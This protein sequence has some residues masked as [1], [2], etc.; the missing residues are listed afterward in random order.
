MKIIIAIILAMGC[1]SVAY[2]QV[3]GY[4]DKEDLGNGLVKVKS[5]N[6][7]GIMDK[8]DNVIVSVEYQDIV[9]R[10]G[11]ALLIK[12]GYLRGIVDSIGNIK[13][14]NGEYKVHPKYKYVSEG[15]IPVSFTIKNL[16]KSME[17]W[18]YVDTNGEPYKLSGKIKGGRFMGKKGVVLFDDVTP[19]VNGMACVY[20][21]KEGW[22]HIDVSGKERFILEDKKPVFRSSVH[23][24]EC[25]IVAEDGIKQYQENEQNKAL[26]KKILSNTATLIN[27]PENRVVFNEGVLELDSLRR[28]V[29]YTTGNDSIVFIEKPRKEVVRQVVVPDDTLSLEDILKVGLSPKVLRANSGGRARVKVKIQ[30]VSD[31][32]IEGVSVVVECAGVKREWDGD[33][34]AH[35]EA[36]LSLNISAKFSV[37]SIKRNVIIGIT[38]KGDSMEQRLPVTINRYTPA[39]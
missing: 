10:E 38:Y 15:F 6:S 5:E 23:K 19:F 11:R 36:S 29:K 31:S 1:A 14:V 30:N 26:V 17:K 13:E 35:S 18:G 27:M 34:E 20:V 9:F 25:V 12:D 16:L 39:R 4:S 8:N 33:L 2:S 24:G 7:Y 28:V 3:L 21:N 22:R 32:K 37:K